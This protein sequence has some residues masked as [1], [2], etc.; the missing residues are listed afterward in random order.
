M[1]S[2]TT[3]RI[4]CD[5]DDCVRFTVESSSG[6][7][8]TIIYAG[9]G[10]GDPDYVGLWKCSCPAGQNGTDCKHMRAFLGSN[11]TD[12]DYGVRAGDAIEVS[13]DGKRTWLPSPDD[14]ARR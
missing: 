7:N 3:M 2:G 5:G 8:Y 13:I 10:D 4:V 9:S 12:F 11:L 14:A 1:A 6:K